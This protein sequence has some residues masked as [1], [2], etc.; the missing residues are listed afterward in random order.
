MWKYANTYFNTYLDSI[1]DVQVS[2]MSL[3]RYETFKSNVQNKT[4]DNVKLIT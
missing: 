2:K 4:I 1:M 3:E